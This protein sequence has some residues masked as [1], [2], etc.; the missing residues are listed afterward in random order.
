M[1]SKSVVVP[2]DAARRWEA[3]ANKW[4]W[5]LSELVWFS[6]EAFLEELPDS[7]L[8]FRPKV[9]EDLLECPP[10]MRELREQVERIKRE[11]RAKYG[12]DP[13]SPEG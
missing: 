9:R 13:D 5:R 7:P 4:G 2:R 11:Q 1:K 12:V 8:E 10:T 6:V 3:V